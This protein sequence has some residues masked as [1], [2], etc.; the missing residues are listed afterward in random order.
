MSRSG[1][2]PAAA[3]SGSCCATQEAGRSVP[4]AFSGL[5][6]KAPVRGLKA[7][8]R[9]GPQGSNVGSRHSPFTEKLP[10]RAFRLA[11]AHRENSPVSLEAEV[12]PDSARGALAEPNSRA[13]LRMGR[14]GTPGMSATLSG[15]KSL[16]T[17]DQQAWP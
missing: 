5:R 11:P 1:I 17:R 13:S 15:E 4:R 7:E 10:D 14:A 6:E 2:S 16:L 9:D 3:R 12:P 8:T